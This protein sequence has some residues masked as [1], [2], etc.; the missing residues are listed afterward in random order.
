MPTARQVLVVRGGWS[1]HSPT[2]ATQLFLPFL[3][4]KGFSVVV[5]DSLEVYADAAFMADVDLILQCWTMGEILPEELSGLRTAVADGTG[6][7]GWHGGIVDSFRMSPAY[8]QLVGAQFAA[9]PGGLVDHVIEVVAQRAHHDIVAGIEPIELRSEQ[10]WLMSDGLNDVLA[11][12][13]IPAARNDPW[14]QPVISP[15]VWTRQWGAGRVFCTA[16]G[17]Q[18]ADLQVPDVRNIVE[19][20]LLWAA[21]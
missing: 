20:G 6:L 2:E 9:H 13:T 3:R 5:S 21:R 18:P 19:R 8:T 7:A 14:Q 11:T 15:A 17:H 4:H 10:Y 16:I 12:T 1:G